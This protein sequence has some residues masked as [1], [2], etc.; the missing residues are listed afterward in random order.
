MY[1]QNSNGIQN[2]AVKEPQQICI[3]ERTAELL[4]SRYALSKAYVSVYDAM[5]MLERGDERKAET[6]LWNDEETG[7]F[8]FFN[9]TSDLIEDELLNNILV[10]MEKTNGQEI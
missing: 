6:I 10:T 2:Q 3:S 8:P 1:N 5:T 4:R 9:K 7:F